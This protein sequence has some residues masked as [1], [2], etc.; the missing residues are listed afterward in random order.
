VLHAGPAS[1]RHPLFRMQRRPC[2]Q[3]AIPGVPRNNAHTLQPGMRALTGN[4]RGAI[5]KVQV[6]TFSGSSDLRPGDT[7]QA[8]LARGTLR[9]SDDV[10]TD[11]T[12]R[13]AGSS[14]ALRIAAA[15]A[16]S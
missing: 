4:Y 7:P 13:E 6:P 12:Q 14:A 10:H 8:A 11:E 1:P 16:P 15:S 3:P 5:C 2:R 9:V